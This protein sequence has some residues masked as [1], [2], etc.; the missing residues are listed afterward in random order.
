MIRAILAVDDKG[1]VSKNGSMPWPKNK[2]DLMWFKENTLNQVVIM[3]RNTWEDSKMPT[4]LKERIN[5]LVT[6]KKNKEYEGADHYINNDLIK[7]INKMKEQYSN[8]TIWLI[9]GPNIINQTFDVIEEFYLTR[10][11]GD[12]MCDKNLDLNSIEINMKKLKHIESDNTCHF[13]IW[14]K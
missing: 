10:I 7:N 1:G 8:K 14:S 13:E 3:G 12:F 11:Y 9:G 6:S 4:P 2:N 5:I